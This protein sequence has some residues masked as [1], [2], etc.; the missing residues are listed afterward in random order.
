M[1]VTLVP[2]PGRRT[3]AA[4]TLVPLIAAGDAP[5]L[6]RDHYAA[7]DPGPIVATLAHVPELCEVAL[8]FVGAALGPSGVSVRDKEIAILRTSANLACRYCV[9]AHTVV[10]SDSGLSPDQMRALRDELPVVASFPDAADRALIAWIDAL[11]AGPGPVDG[12]TAENARAELGDHRLVELTVTVG[13][14]WLLN[15]MATGLR[16]P[17]SD[18]ALRRLGELGFE[19]TLTTSESTNPDSAHDGRSTDGHDRR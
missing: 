12:S 15:R 14:T 9:N 6:V 10:A 17:T 8:P 3:P 16:L 11:T 5:L 4:E 19:D 1:S 18:D 2:T 13:A 7:G